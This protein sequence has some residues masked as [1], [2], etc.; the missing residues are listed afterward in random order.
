MKSINIHQE[1][2]ISADPFSQV[3]TSDSHTLPSK[4][5]NS[6]AMSADPLLQV[7]A[8]SGHILPSQKPNSAAKS[9]ELLN[10][11]S[12]SG[13]LILSTS[14]L[15]ATTTDQVIAAK[16]KQ[17]NTRQ[18]IILTANRVY[19][20]LKRTNPSRRGLEAL[21]VE[22]GQLMEE[23]TP[24]HNFLVM[25]SGIMEK[26][27]EYQ[28]SSHLSY[29]LLIAEVEDHVQDYLNSRA[30]DSASSIT[31]VS[32]LPITGT[33][34]VPLSRGS[35]QTITSAVAVN[36]TFPE[37]DNNSAFRA[38]ATRTNLYGEGE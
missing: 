23:A 27:L 8:S 30:D 24:V 26:K 31:F 12:A 6:A 1:K 10:Q 25:Y 9:V 13:G 2:A 34:T 19:D 22:L 29:R 33:K 35:Q 17:K 7:S 20:V 18:L 3:P 16:R 5:P 37:A 15:T 4:E 21:V 14:T 38:L 11:A 32:S 28:Q 36:E